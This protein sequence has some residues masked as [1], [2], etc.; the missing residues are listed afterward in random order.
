M[1]HRHEQEGSPGERLLL[2]GLKPRPNRTMEQKFGF[3]V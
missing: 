1:R 2:F 3:E